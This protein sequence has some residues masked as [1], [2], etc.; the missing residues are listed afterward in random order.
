MKATS[1]VLAVCALITG[2]VAAWKW[3]EASKVY[4]KPNWK[5]EPVDP[6]LKAMSWD[7]ATLEAFDRAGK[8][9]AVA[10]LWT[11]ISVGLG[12]TSSIIGSLS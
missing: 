11:A 9:N 6:T 2:L 3:Y 4:P 5:F 8:L 12:S 7:A 1:I 10:A